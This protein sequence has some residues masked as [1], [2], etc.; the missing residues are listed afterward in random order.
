M[1]KINDSTALYE[2]SIRRIR[3]YAAKSGG[4]EK[5]FPIFLFFKFFV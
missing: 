1:E 3:G 5:F 2:K 4:A